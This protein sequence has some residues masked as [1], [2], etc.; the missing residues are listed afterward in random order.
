MYR[1]ELRDILLQEFAIGAAVVRPVVRPEVLLERVLMFVG[2]LNVSEMGRLVTDL[3]QN[4]CADIWPLDDIQTT[5]IPIVIWNN[6]N[7]WKINA[8]SAS[9]ARPAGPIETE[10]CDSFFVKYRDHIQMSVTRR[11]ENKLLGPGTNNY[12]ASM[13][14]GG[15]SNW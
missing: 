2:I 1:S 4:D 10:S 3:T 5:L 15:G 14:V 8:R 7:G 12:A 6:H 11:R 13:T 9:T